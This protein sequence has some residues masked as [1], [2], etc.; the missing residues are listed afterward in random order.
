MKSL[1]NRAVGVFAIVLIV[2]PIC[3]QTWTQATPTTSPAARLQHAMT[4]D[5]ARQ[6]VVLFGGANATYFGDTWAWDGS[7]ATGNMG[8]TF[9]RAHG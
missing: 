8:N 6:Q 7:C 5:A 4:Y 2:F 1:A 3:A 9:D